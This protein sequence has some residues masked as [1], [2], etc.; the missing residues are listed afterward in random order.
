[1]D[2]S[3]RTSRSC[4]CHKRTLPC[5]T[6]HPNG[7]S[8]EQRHAA[9]AGSASRDDLLTAAE[10]LLHQHGPK[11]LTIRRLADEVD[12]SRQVVYSRFGGKDGLLRALHDKGF[13]RLGAAIEAIDVPMGTDDHILALADTYRRAAR[14]APAL[15]DLMFGQR[16]P[17]LEGDPAARLMAERAFDGI[18][19]GA[20]AW[21]EA[22][23]GERQGTTSL[24][25]AL[26]SA[27]HG[28]VALERAG[29]LD[30]VTAGREL[31]GLMRRVLRGSLGEVRART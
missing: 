6:T 7:A 21:L 9:R 14:D 23:R 26:W 25:L 30:D 5:C 22:Q 31:H 16:G 24:A 11:A 17:A 15:F 3:A 13:R 8:I 18:V 12:A 27:T 20:G 4:H 19:R 1:M 29:H 10:Q 28:V 2:N